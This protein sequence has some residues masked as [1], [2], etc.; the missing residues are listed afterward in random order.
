MT[1]SDPTSPGFD[2]D[3]W[4]IFRIQVGAN[5]DNIPVTDDVPSVPEPGTL[6]ILALG[7]LGAAATRRLKAGA[8]NS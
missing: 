3:E 7:L 8:R 5:P 6:S 2:H 4:L 1:L